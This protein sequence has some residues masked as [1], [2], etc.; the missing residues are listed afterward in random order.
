MNASILKSKPEYKFIISLL[1][2]TLVIIPKGG[3]KVSSIPIT[4]G[5]VLTFLISFILVLDLRNLKKKFSINKQRSISILSLLP[6]QFICITSLFFNGFT[7]LGF[8]ISLIIN[9]ILLPWIYI[10][11]FGFYFDKMNF[12]FFFRFLK[13]AI[14][15]ISIYG[16]FLFFFKFFTGSFIEI[17]FVTINQGDIG[18]ISE[19]NIDRGEVFKLISTYNNGNIY[20]VCML[21]LLPLY[22]SFEKNLLKTLIVKTSIIL[23]LS[24]TVWAGLFIYEIIYRIYIRKASLKSVLYFIVSILLSVFAVLYV[25]SFAGLDISFLFDSTL[26]GRDSQL[27]YLSNLQFI[28]YESFASIGEVVY[29]SIAKYFGILGLILFSIGMT[30]PILLNFISKKRSIKNNQSTIQ[31]SII[32]GLIIYLFVSLSDGAFLLIPVMSFYWFLYSL[33]LSQNLTLE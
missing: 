32:S 13:F 4:W 25:L 23:T 1:V 18:N 30:T 5:Y 24:R 8:A 2:L 20:G 28:S 9:I 29:I 15:S 7:D 19:K 26:G 14:I 31:K 33:L 27:S 11:V 3:I 21:M 10:V 22:S 17:P 12:T 6:F 16:I